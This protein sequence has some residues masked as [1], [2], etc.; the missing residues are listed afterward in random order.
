MAVPNRMNFRKSSKGGVGGMGVFS[1][2][3]NTC[4]V[5]LP[6]LPLSCLSSLFLFLFPVVLHHILAVSILFLFSPP[7][8]SS[9]ASSLFLPLAKAINPQPVAGSAPTSILSNNPQS[10]ELHNVD[11][12]TKKVFT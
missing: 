8:S 7:F 3:L 1:Y 12:A 5:I 9:C 11:F 2:S 4:F 10:T 6:S